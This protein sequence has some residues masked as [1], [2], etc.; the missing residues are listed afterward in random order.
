VRGGAEVDRDV[1][2]ENRNYTNSRLEESHYIIFKKYN[3]ASSIV[4]CIVYH[5]KLYHNVRVVFI[6]IKLNSKLSKSINNLHATKS[7]VHTKCERKDALTRGAGVDYLQRDSFTLNKSHNCTKT[8]HGYSQQ[9]L[10]R[11]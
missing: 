6:I 11:I 7:G 4:Q 8:N 3:I 10:H 2:E 1:D 9:A 5:R